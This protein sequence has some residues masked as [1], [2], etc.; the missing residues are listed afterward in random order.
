MASVCPLFS[1]KMLKN[2]MTTT[3]VIN[4]TT[5]ASRRAAPNSLFARGYLTTGGQGVD[6]DRAMIEAAGFRVAEVVP[7]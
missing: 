2:P 1:Q 3:K 4:C 6:A 5:L 7:A